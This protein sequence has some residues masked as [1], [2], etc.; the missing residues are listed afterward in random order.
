[1]SSEATSYFQPGTCSQSQS[2]MSRLQ[3]VQRHMP[4]WK[5]TETSEIKLERTPMMKSSVETSF[6]RTP[7]T[8]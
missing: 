5:P 8:V 7:G 2:Q 6:S 4:P 1:M 3:M